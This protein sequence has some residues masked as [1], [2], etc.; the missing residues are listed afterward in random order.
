M[1]NLHPAAATPQLPRSEW[2]ALSPALVERLRLEGVKSPSDWR[3]LGRNRF[4][5]F[6]ITRAMALRLDTLARDV[7]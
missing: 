6:G 1:Q 7:P 2:D 4:R 5:L 3:A